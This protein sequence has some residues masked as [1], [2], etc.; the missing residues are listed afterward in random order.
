M[1]MPQCLLDRIV[2]K[3]F[4]YIRV[5]LPPFLVVCYIGKYYLFPLLPII[6]SIDVST[7]I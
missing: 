5:C 4:C 2:K 6:I 7:I 1:S 3:A